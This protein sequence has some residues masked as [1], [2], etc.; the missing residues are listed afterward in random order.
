MF[1]YPLILLLLILYLPLPAINTLSPAAPDSLKKKKPKTDSLLVFTYKNDLEKY[2]KLKLVPSDTALTGSQNYDPLYAYSRFYGTLGNIGSANENLAPYPIF[3]PSGFDFGIHSFDQYLFSNDSVKYYKVL[4]T[5][6]DLHYVQGAKK[7]IFLHAIFTRN[8][9]RSLNIGFDFRVFNSVGA[10]QFQRTNGINF[11]L[12]AQYYSRNRRYGVIANFLFNRLRNN[13]NGGIK[14][15][16]MFTDNVE[17]NRQVYTVNLLHAQ[18]R[19]K[20]IGFYMKHVFD[21]TN[22]NLNPRDSGASPA[23][24]IDLGRIAY[25]FQYNRQVQNYIDYDP[26]SGFYPDIYLDTVQTYDSLTITK[27]VNEITWTNPGFR[28]DL[29]PRVL[30]LVAHFKQM[31]NEISLHSIKR[32]FNQYIPAA[33]IMFHPYSSLNLYAY[34]DYV[35]GAYNQGDLSLKANLTQVLG[36]PKHNLGSITL[37]AYSCFQQPGLFYEQWLGNNYK[38]DTTWKKQNIIAGGFSY[39]FK[40][41]NAGINISR[42]GNFVYLDSAIKPRQFTPEFGYIYAYLNGSAKLWRFTLTGQFAYQTI[43]GTNVLR[44]PSFLGNL[45]IYYTQPLFHGAA[46]FQPGFT[47]FYNTFYYGNAYSPAIR[48]FYLQDNMQTGNYPYIDA[49][50]NVKIQRARIF[51]MYSHCNAS[52]MGRSYIMVPDYPMQDGA[53]K[54]GVSWNFHD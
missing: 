45:G 13:E 9:F 40:T 49:F 20:D 7:E 21:L 28:P 6:S 10:Y 19:V 17:S 14:Y 3:G 18:N 24:R 4:K 37:N 53:F 50:L 29:K 34:G 23:S 33:E 35:F 16:T 32:H 41:L 5:Y 47:V 26:K 36:S 43:Q 42:I 48:S 27:F 54:F 2:G 11:Y 30:Q 51:V 15:D 44:L 12:T 1:K 46:T 52:F 25:S 39:T 22:H 31:Y 8:I 38:W